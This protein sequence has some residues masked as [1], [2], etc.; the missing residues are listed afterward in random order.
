M[1]RCGGEGALP[2]RDTLVEWRLRAIERAYLPGDSATAQ[3]VAWLA[4]EL[5]R[6]RQALTQMLALS[7]EFGQDPPVGRTFGSEVRAS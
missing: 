5:R 2:A 3:D 6:A 4:F 1:S 7:Q